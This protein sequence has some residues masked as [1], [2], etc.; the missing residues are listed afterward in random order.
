[1]AIEGSSLVRKSAAVARIFEGGK[2]RASQFIATTM[3]A[4]APMP[5]AFRWR[6]ESGRAKVR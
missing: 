2:A 4:R 5:E 1:M 3:N 6:D